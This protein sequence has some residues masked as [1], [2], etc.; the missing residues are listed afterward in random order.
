MLGWS[1]SSKTQG[2]QPSKKLVLVGRQAPTRGH[3]W[4]ASVGGAP[5]GPPQEHKAVS[6]SV[7]R[8]PE[9]A[10]GENPR[11]AEEEEVEAIEAAM[12]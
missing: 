4:L 11:E 10:S 3:S 8:D 1:T 7:Y 5:G 6:A 12:G 9:A 2:A